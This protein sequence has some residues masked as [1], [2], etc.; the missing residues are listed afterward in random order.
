MKVLDRSRRLINFKLSSLAV[1]F[2]AFNFL[3]SCSQHLSLYYFL[4]LTS[5]EC[6][7]K[8]FRG[9]ASDGVFLCRDKEQARIGFESLIRQPQFGGGINEAVLIQV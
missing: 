9:V 3:S 5:A 8:P 4:L 2:L 6:V 1:H 7:V